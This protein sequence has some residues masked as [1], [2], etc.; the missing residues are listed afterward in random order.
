MSLALASAT[1]FD[2][3]LPSGHFHAQRFGSPN[4]PLALCIP[5]LSAN[6]KSFDFICERIAGER[7][8][9]VALDLRGRGKSEVTAAGTYGWPSHARDVFAA[10]DALGAKSFSVI[11]H[12]MGGLVAMAA[13][14]QDAARLE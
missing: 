11:G 7:L 12:S 14:A 5:G 6:I 1:E 9:T 2:L 13:S 3:D 4:A 10:A 8:Q